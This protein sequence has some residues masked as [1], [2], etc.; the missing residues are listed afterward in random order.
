MQRASC[1]NGLHRALREA[2]EGA[3]NADRGCCLEPSIEEQ[4]VIKWGDE[5]GKSVLQACKSWGSWMAV[6]PEPWVCMWRGA[7]TVGFGA[8]R[9]GTSVMEDFVC[10]AKKLGFY[11]KAKDPCEESW[12]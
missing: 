4:T 5:K 8:N 3:L 2:G 7:G 11:L 1:K 9:S 12:I 6:G 10:H